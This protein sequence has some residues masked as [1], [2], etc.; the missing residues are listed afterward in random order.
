MAGPLGVPISAVSFA[1]HRFEGRSS[2]RRWW[3]RWVDG[4][5]EVTVVPDAM[6]IDFAGGFDPVWF[7]A[8]M[9]GEDD[10]EKSSSLS[11]EIIVVFTADKMRRMGLGA[12]E[13]VNV[14]G[15]G[16]RR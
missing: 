7:V 15:P 8:A 2:R 6:R 9:P 5:V 3:G 11:D 16:P 12:D 10:P 4:P 13:F 14:G 1:W